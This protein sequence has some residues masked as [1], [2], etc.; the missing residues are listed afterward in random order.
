MFL[1]VYIKH[2]NSLS[3]F[4]LLYISHMQYQ[5]HINSSH[6][7]SIRQHSKYYDQGFNPLLKG[8]K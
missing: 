4:F 2:A 1:I 7:H 3:A 8:H 5:Q 6:G